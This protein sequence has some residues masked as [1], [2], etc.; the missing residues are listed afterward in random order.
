MTGKKILYPFCISESI[1]RGQL[2]RIVLK[3]IRS[4]PEKARLLTTQLVAESFNAV[5][6]CKTPG[7]PDARSE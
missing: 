5:F 6:P 2:V 3:Y 1:D 7:D 4:H